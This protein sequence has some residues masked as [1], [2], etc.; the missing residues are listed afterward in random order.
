VS[1]PTY[2]PVIPKSER[3]R[4]LLSVGAFN[5]ILREATA[6]AGEQ[7]IATFLPL[8]FDR[9]Y[10]VGLGYAASQRRDPWAAKYPG[11]IPETYDQRKVAWQGHDDP[12]VWTGRLRADIF[13]RA[14]A[15]AVATKGNV[16]GSIR[17]GALTITTKDGFRQM[18]AGSMVRRILTA[19]PPNEADFLSTQA[20][21]YIGARLD[22]ITA[23]VKS[24]KRLPAA[25]P[26]RPDFA[27]AR[28]AAARNAAVQRETIGGRMRQRIALRHAQRQAWRE[29]SGGSAG[30]GRRSLSASERIAQHRSQSLA[31]YHR[32]AAAINRRRRL[33]RMLGVAVHAPSRHP[34]INPVPT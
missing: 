30:L 4:A 13:A 17:L 31:S 32:N 6:H 9:S 25:P 27:R 8:R 24:A 29:E 34:T 23:P 5:A 26:V 14:R 1:G 12:L 10:A 18:K 11:Q 2:N 7:W 15:T 22:A 19:L 20:T 33:S 3:G 28:L 16:Q 21:A